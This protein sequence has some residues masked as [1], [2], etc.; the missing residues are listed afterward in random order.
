M[1]NRDTSIR[2]LARFYLGIYLPIAW[3]YHGPALV[4]IANAGDLFGFAAISIACTLAI[5]LVCWLSIVLCMQVLGLLLPRQ[6]QCIVD[7]AVLVAMLSIVVGAILVTWLADW[8]LPLR[9]T[10]VIPITCAVCTSIA[11]LRPASASQVLSQ[12]T[13][14]AWRLMRVPLCVALVVGTGAIVVALA[15]SNSTLSTPLPAG[16]I[17]VRQVG[18]TNAGD[19]RRS[20]V[21]LTID[22]FSAARSN[23]Y[24]APENTTPFITEFARHAAVFDMAIASA[25]FTASSSAT[26]QTGEYPW[27]H[28]ILQH[29]GYFLRQPATLALSLHNAGYR[30][31]Y[32]NANWFADPRHT[33]SAA[34]WDVTTGPYQAVP[35]PLARRLCALAVCDTSRLATVPPLAEVSAAY[36]YAV[37]RLGLLERVRYPP[38]PILDDA[39]NWIIKNSGSGPIFVWIHLFPPHDPYFPPVPFLYSLLPKKTLDTVSQLMSQP[40]YIFSPWEASQLHDLQERYKESLRYVD[41]RL[42][43]FLRDPRTSEFIDHSIVIITSDHG[44]SFERNYV[45]HNGPLLTQSLIHIPLIIRTPEMRTMSRIG[46]AVSQTDVM[47]TVLDLVGVPVPKSV[48]GISLKPFLEGQTLAGSRVVFAMNFERATAHAPLIHQGHSVA[49]VDWP[50]KYVEYEAVPRFSPELYDLAHDASEKV[51]LVSGQ[52]QMVRRYSTVLNQAIVESDTKKRE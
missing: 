51:N 37:R 24:G 2:L 43:G 16:K 35:I 45:G 20:V 42:G 12:V 26:I 28:R 49:L 30:T 13:G 34:G 18:A 7:T 11:V 9:R 6:L 15:T 36:E 8:G 5:A 47:P 40:L 31:A 25:N 39:R 22:A 52:Q 10:V 3:L 23:L 14:Q 33:Q 48:D 38:D 21:L 17:P 32:F 41:E 50:W 19:D 27:T 29:Q 1:S 46:T 4:S 44:E